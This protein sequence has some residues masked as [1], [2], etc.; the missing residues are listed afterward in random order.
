MAF[1]SWPKVQIQTPDGIVN[2]IAPIIISAS[3]ATDIPAFHA[4]RFIKS[5]ETGYTK[6]VNPFNQVPQYVSFEN[7]RV[8]VFWT[9][10]PDPMIPLLKEVEKRGINYYFTYTLNDYVEEGLEPNLPALKKRIETFRKLSKMIGKERVIWRF[11][12]LLLSDKLTVE[13]L[14]DKIKSVG[15][16]IHNHTEK[17]VFS[18]VDISDYS[19]VKRNLASKNL[20]EFREFSPDEKIQVAKG[21]QALNKKWNLQLATCCEDVDLVPYGVEHNQCID[22]ELMI[23]L[24][25][26]DKILMD[27]LG[28]DTSTR[29]ISLF[30]TPNK[31]KE[32]KLKDKGQRKTCGC[33]VS[34]DI[35]QYNTCMHLC[36]YCYANHSE[37]RVKSNMKKF[38]E[39]K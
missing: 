27:F 2:G 8:I 28:V 30:D 17:L 24:F 9:K 20:G 19:A 21:I 13:K 6:W 26:K 3:R 37:G 11:D 12:P 35:G 14:L 31:P 1:K 34:K 18:F 38:S 22:D 5:L 32:N 16:K 29:Q 25:R 33:I 10:N 39:S 7:A 4:D 15:E 23:R 36:T